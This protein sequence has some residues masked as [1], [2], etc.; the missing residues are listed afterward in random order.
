MAMSTYETKHLHSGKVFERPFILEN[1]LKQDRNRQ[2]PQNPA[3]SFHKSL[4][5]YNE[6]RLHDVT[7]LASELGYSRVFV[8]DESNRFGLPAFKI[9][10]ASWGVHNAICQKI[11]VV[12]ADTSFNDLASLLKSN[13][14]DIQLVTC[15]VGNW[16]RAVARMGRLLDIPVRIYVP[17][18]TSEYTKRLIAEEGA[19]LR[20][21]D[22]SGYDEYLAVV[23]EDAAST[24]ALL[25]QDVSWEGYQDVPSWAM[26]GYRTMLQEAERQ[27]EDATGGQRASVVVT[28]VGGGLWAKSTLEHY[29]A[30]DP[31]TKV[32]TVEA[33]TAA[34][35][36]ESL[37]CG[38]NT[39]VTTSNT[40]MAGLNGGITDDL[41]W[42]TLRDGV[43]IAAVVTDRESHESVD[44]LQSHGINAGPC[45]GATLAALRKVCNTV[46]M[47]DRQNLVVVLFSTEGN[48]E[49]ELPGG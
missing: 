5:D 21:I 4:P 16:G 44:Y 8:K 22:G 17:V 19:D 18:F 37:H 6:T 25:V 36:K 3:E 27:V 23:Q 39:T 31:S 45:G 40:I 20:D 7:A 32:I 26:E 9:L 46:D 29:K 38:E 35:F 28:G 34:G 42:S 41:A 49:Y 15:S 24:G 33:D 30:N 2:R 11:G 13:L 1:P 48:R 43:D 10:G 14:E 47:K 12:A